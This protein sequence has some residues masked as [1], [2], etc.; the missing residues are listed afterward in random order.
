MTD[1][2]KIVMQA[3]ID[4]PFLIPEGMRIWT[5]Q[6]LNDPVT[7]EGRQVIH[8]VAEAENEDAARQCLSVAA[9][10]VRSSLADLEF[11]GAP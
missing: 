5:T 2:A 3:K 10:R 1:E 7:R 4:V 6:L 11:L 8:I 9:A